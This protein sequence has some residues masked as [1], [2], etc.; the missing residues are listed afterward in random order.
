MKKIKI[1]IKV[2]ERI[3]RIDNIHNVSIFFDCRTVWQLVSEYY[4]IGYAAVSVVVLYNFKGWGN[5]NIDCN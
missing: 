4:K 1:F 2:A 5:S 3:F